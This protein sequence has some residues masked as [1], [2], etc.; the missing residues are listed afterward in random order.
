MSDNSFTLAPWGLWIFG[1][2]GYAGLDVYLVMMNCNPSIDYYERLFPEA[3]L[4][5]HYVAPGP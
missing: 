5:P 1:G 4:T 2:R 3:K